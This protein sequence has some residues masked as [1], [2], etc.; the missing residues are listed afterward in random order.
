MPPARQA[1]T[2][3]RTHSRRDPRTGATQTVRRHDRNIK[4][5]PNP[6]HAWQMGKKAYAHGRNG[7]HAAAAAAG[8]WAVAEICLF[9]AGDILGAVLLA[10]GALLFGVGLAAM[11]HHLR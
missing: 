9:L 11:R 6:G 8:L 3:V 10:A 5:G 1:R 2:S 4:R 7:R